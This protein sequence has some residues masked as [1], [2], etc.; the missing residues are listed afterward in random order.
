MI[1]SQGIVLSLVSPSNPQRLTFDIAV[2]PDN[3]PLH[4]FDARKPGFS[5]K[6]SHTFSSSYL[7]VITL[8]VHR[9]LDINNG[10]QI[11]QPAA[12]HTKAQ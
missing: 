6:A 4:G 5:G 3:S 1:A 7:L 8:S 12:A 10:I 11:R 2:K 9:M